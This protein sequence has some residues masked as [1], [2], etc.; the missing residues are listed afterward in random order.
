MGI[1][2]SILIAVSLCADCFAV[3]LCSSVTLMSLRWPNV[4]RVTA[5]FAV[6]GFPNGTTQLAEGQLSLQ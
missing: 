1:L 3:T 4:L 5:V 6:Q 2:E